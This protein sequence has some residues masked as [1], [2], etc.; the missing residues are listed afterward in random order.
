MNSVLEKSLNSIEGTRSH[1][2]VFSL[3]IRRT[4]TPRPFIRSYTLLEKKN[5]FSLLGQ[6]LYK[7]AFFHITH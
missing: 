3:A 6:I 1:L 7:L 2:H 5:V 4:I